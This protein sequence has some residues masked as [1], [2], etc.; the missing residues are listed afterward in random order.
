[1]ASRLENFP[2]LI[3]RLI[4]ALFLIF[5]IG[6]AIISQIQYIAG[7]LD[8]YST[9][10]LAPLFLFLIGFLVYIQTSDKQ[11][12]GNSAVVLMVGFSVAIRT[13]VLLVL[14]TDLTSDVL[15]VHNYAV[16]IVRGDPTAHTDQYTY[17]PEATY[18][19]MTGLTHALFY[20]LFG[21]SVKTAKLLSV[22]VGAITVAGVA[23]HAVATNI[24]RRKQIQHGIETSAPDPEPGKEE[25]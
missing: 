14:S 23:A 22:A 7:N 5:P 1:M 12:S 24:R 20:K 11:G 4:L 21:A 10:L 2:F 17:I 25:T 19:S 3:Q 13:A 15:D 8:L 16:D 6:L 9:L 18:L